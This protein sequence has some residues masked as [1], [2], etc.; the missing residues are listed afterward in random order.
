MPKTKNPN[1]LKLRTLLIYG[2]FTALLAIILKWLEYRFWIRG[3]MIELYVGLIAGMF[4][5]LGIWMGL[6][7]T[8]RRQQGTTTL[9]PPVIPNAEQVKKIGLSAREQEVLALIARGHSNQE[10]ADQL[11]VSLSTV[12]THVSN[13]LSKLDVKRRTQAI[14]KAKEL[15]ILH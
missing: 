6:K 8:S 13:V 10:I 3:H 1:P 9:H 11:F 2:F 12:K 5:L 15:N 14:Q 4:L 7:W